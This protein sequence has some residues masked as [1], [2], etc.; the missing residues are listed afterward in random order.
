MALKIGDIQT[1]KDE[2]EWVIVAITH[3]GVSRVRKDSLAHRVHAKVSP[4]IAKSLS[5]IIT[6]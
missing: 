1:D 3:S 4:E 2:S 6:H 5:P